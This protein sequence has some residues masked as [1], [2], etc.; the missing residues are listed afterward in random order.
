V[1]W[2]LGF[3]QTLDAVVRAPGHSGGFHEVQRQE[4]EAVAVEAGQLTAQFT[5]TLLH[6]ITHHGRAL[7]ARELAERQWEVIV[8][9][10][11]FLCSGDN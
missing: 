3:L 1:D 2:A 7:A 9:R 8:R 11:L 4:V 6:R 10:Q 5:R